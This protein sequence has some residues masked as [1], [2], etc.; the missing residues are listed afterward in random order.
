MARARGANALMAAK[1]ETT[2]GTPPAGNYM[3]MPFVSSALG[4]ERGLIESDLLGQGRESYDP[5]PDVANN[6]GDVVVPV[7]LRRF[8][9]WLKLFFGPATTVAGGSGAANV[10]TFVSG[11]AALPSLSVEV[12][13]PQVPSFGMNYGVTGNIMRIAMSRGGLLNATLGL[14][15]QGETLSSTT[16]AGTP[17]AVTIERFAQATGTVKQGATTLADIVSADFT[18]SNSIDKVEVIRGD[19]RIGGADAGMAMA[20]G[21]IVCR[22]GDTTLLD[23]ATGGT[24]VDLNFGWTKAGTPNSSLLF[25]LPRVFLPRS[26]RPITGPAGVQ[27]SFNFQASGQG[28]HVCTVTLSNDVTGYA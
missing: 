1:F 4:E 9:Q 15:A 14:I 13:L 20:S 23:I 3:Q 10:H 18:F 5:T 21:T 12:G 27:A 24:P 22:F 16:S 28:G 8:G 17:S 26:K 25:D 19:G 7:D 11:A 2:Y 6:D